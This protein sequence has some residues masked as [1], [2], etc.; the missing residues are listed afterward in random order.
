M[1]LNIYKEQ[2]PTSHDIV[3]KIRKITKIRKVGHTGT[4]DQLAND[5]GKKLKSGTYLEELIRTKIGKYNIKDSVRIKDL[6]SKNWTNY[7]TTF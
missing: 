7:L 2:G 5:I 6:N 4:L 1:I 3:D